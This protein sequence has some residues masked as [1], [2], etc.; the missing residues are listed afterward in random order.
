MP[1]SGNGSGEDQLLARELT[2]AALVTLLPLK[3][4]R[5]NP[6]ITADLRRWTKAAQDA[7]AARGGTSDVTAVPGGER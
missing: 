3:T 5:G 4:A 1:Q 7:R 6:Q 2:P